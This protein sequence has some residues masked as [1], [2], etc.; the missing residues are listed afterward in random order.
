MKKQKLKLFINI[1]F[2]A[3]WIIIVVNA[4]ISIYFKDLLLSDIDLLC[5]YISKRNA[6]F[7]FAL[8]FIG[9]KFATKNYLES[10]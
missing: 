10:D 2:I 8:L 1:L 5:S 4:A 7:I 9:L 6:S 3:A